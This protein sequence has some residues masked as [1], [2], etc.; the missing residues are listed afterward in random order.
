MHFRLTL[1]DGTLVD[2]TSPDE[3]LE[4]R[5]DDDSLIEGLKLALL[6]LKA[7]DKQTLV[8]PPETGFGPRDPEAIHHLPRSD[9][10]ADI[11]PRPGRIIG[12]HLPDGE[13]VAGAILSVEGDQVEV[14]FNHPCAGH[15]VTFS[16]E[17]LDVKNA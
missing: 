1:E 15:E 11:E 5:M 17:I 14:D 7:G 12:F 16:V 8:I 6:D 9:F 10:P 2:A 4:F 3:P 13:E